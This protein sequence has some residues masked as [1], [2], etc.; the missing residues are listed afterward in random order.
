MLDGFLEKGARA[1]GAVG[2]RH[3]GVSPEDTSNRF[4]FEEMKSSAGGS[5][6]YTHILEKN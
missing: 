3:W 6:M 5:R 2:E 4:Q 1:E